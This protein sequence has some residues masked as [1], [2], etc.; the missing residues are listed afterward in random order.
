MN[1]NEKSDQNI[2]D[3]RHR[4]LT[5]SNVVKT[6]YSKKSSHSFR[7]WAILI[8]AS[9]A[10]GLI[11]SLK[12]TPRFDDSVSSR[13]G[14]MENKPEMLILC[15]VRRGLSEI[16]Q[17][18]VNSMLCNMKR[19]LRRASHAL[20]HENKV[21]CVRPLVESIAPLFASNQISLQGCNIEKGSL[22]S[23][24][25]LAFRKNCWFSSDIQSSSDALGL[26]KTT[27]VTKQMGPNT[28]VS[29]QSAAYTGLNNP[30]GFWITSPSLFKR[31]P[32][33]K[34]ASP[35][36]HSIIQTGVSSG[37]M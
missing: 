3:F 6:H 18:F 17:C 33:I 31:R 34:L 28:F 21:R 23:G 12:G 7:P 19:I 5:K 14:A 24:S 35:V 2:I 30:E 16:G 27:N 37:C 32:M 25:S 13:I 20:S 1:D 4:I 22:P 15:P 9:E 10:S 29:H 8:A 26:A 36:S 11:T